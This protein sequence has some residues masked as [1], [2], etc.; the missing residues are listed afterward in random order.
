MVCFDEHFVR[1]DTMVYDPATN[2]PL[3]RYAV[4]HEDGRELAKFVLAAK[5]GLTRWEI[6]SAAKEALKAARRRRHAPARLDL[7]A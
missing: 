5:S 7:A 6:Q 3:Q 4:Y 2:E 1:F